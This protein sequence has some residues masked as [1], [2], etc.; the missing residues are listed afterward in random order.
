M[1]PTT[2]SF[3]PSKSTASFPHALFW[4]AKHELINALFLLAFA[5]QMAYVGWTLSPF[6]MYGLGLAHI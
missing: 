1:L 4:H 3:W 2:L 6:C 5:N